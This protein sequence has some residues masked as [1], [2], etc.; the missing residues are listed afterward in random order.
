MEMSDNMS[1]GYMRMRQRVLRQEL[2]DV[3]SLATAV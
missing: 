2:K 3:A 1:S